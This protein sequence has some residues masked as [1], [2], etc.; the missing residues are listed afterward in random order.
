MATPVGNFPRWAPLGDPC[1]FI[2]WVCKGIRWRWGTEV[3]VC[4]ALIFLPQS[5]QGL[6]SGHV[7]HIGTN[8]GKIHW[9]LQALWPA[10]K[11]LGLA[12]GHVCHIGTRV[13]R[14]RSCRGGATKLHQPFPQW[15]ILGT[16]PWEVLL[17][18]IQFH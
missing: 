9:H 15:V 10:C 11:S 17:D 6:A 13:T 8:W 5:A 16:L 2:R 14:L 3:L 18:C 7:C 12:T 4:K 1:N